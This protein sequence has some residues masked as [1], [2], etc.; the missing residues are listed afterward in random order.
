MSEVRNSE[1]K[2]LKH[3]C[4][5]STNQYA[6][7]FFSGHSGSGKTAEINH[8]IASPEMQQKFEVIKVNLAEDVSV[9]DLNFID[10]IFEIMAAII[11]YLQENH[12]QDLKKGSTEFLDPLYD[13]FCSAGGLLEQVNDVAVTASEKLMDLSKQAVR[14]QCIFK[15]ATYTKEETRNRLEPKMAELIECINVML[16]G[17]NRMIAPKQLLLVVDDLNKMDCQCIEQIIVQCLGIIFSL[18]VKIIFVLP[19]ALTVFPSFARVRSRT[20]ASFTLGI[21]NPLDKNVSVAKKSIQAL[22]QLILR[23]AEEC[24]FEKGAL[25]VLIKKSDGIL[26]DLFYLLIDAF[27]NAS[28]KHP[29]TGMIR[30]DDVYKAQLRLRREYVSLIESAAH[31]NYLKVVYETPQKTFENGILAS[32]LQNNLVIEYDYTKNKLLHPLVVDYM[33]SNSDIV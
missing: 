9:Q 31:Y 27:L 11:L 23:R 16:Q 5:G 3:F 28:I 33:K 30:L 22:Q 25:D 26:K 13:Y 8:L 19:T 18:C 20:N 12:S 24:L 1:I 32:L 21:P 14:G 17:I 15:T 29:E 7:I 10:F 2:K 4:L 6:K